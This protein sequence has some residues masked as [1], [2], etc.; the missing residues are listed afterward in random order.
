MSHSSRCCHHGRTASCRKVSGQESELCWHC[1]GSMVCL[2]L[3]NIVALS[4]QLKA[5]GICMRA[6]LHA[7]LVPWSIKRIAKQQ[8]DFLGVR[9]QRFSIASARLHS[10]VPPGSGTSKFRDVESSQVKSATP[11]ACGTVDSPAVP[12]SLGTVMHLDSCPSCA[13]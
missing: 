4:Q 5:A 13:Q 7:L 6:W 12:Q 3:H 10:S 1:W 9:L 11:H 8:R 2:W